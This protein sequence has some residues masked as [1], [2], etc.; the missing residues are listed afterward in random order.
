MVVTVN[1]HPV[2]VPELVNMPLESALTHSEKPIVY[3]LETLVG[4]VG[5]VP[6]LKVGA[7]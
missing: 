6:Q 3:V 7:T 4:E 5:A 2:A 1:V